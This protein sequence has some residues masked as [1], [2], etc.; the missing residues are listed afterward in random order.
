ME[1]VTPRDLLV[2]PGQVAHH[3]WGDIA[4]LFLLTLESL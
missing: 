2:R 3:P 1:L 4:N